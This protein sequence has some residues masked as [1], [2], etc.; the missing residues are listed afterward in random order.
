MYRLPIDL[1]HIK[2]LLIT[3]L[4]PLIKTTTHDLLLSL[5]SGGGTGVSE[6]VLFLPLI[7]LFMLWSMQVNRGV[8]CQ[9]W[10]GVVGVVFNMAVLFAIGRSSVSLDYVHGLIM[11]QTYPTTILLPLRILQM[12]Q[13]LLM[14]CMLIFQSY[15]LLMPMVRTSLFLTF[16]YKIGVY[17][18]GE[19]LQ[20]RPIKMRRLRHLLIRRG[21]CLQ[22]GILMIMINSING[23]IVSQCIIPLL[24]C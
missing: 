4:L 11:T 14:H 2:R 10:L 5:W 23:A 8:S 13:I 1:I 6:G 15:G 20:I 24:N 17:G 21:V 3:L 18:A 22:N 9:G 12:P 19:M 7:I 16:Y